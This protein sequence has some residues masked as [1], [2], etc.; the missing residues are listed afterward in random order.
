MREALG[1]PHLDSRRGGSLPLELHRALGDPRLQAQRQRPRVRP[2]RAGARPPTRS[3]T[4][5]SSTCA[6][7]RACAGT[8]STS[9]SRCRPRARSTRSAALSLR[10]G[11]GR[12]PAFAVALAAALREDAEEQE[13]DAAGRRSP[14]PSPRPCPSWPRCCA[15]RPRRGPSRRREV[16]IVF[17]ER[18]TVGPGRRRGRRG[19]AADRLAA[20]PR[21]DRPA[22]ACSRSLRS[23]TAAGCA[24][25]ACCRTRG[26]ASPSRRSAA[27]ATRRRSP[28]A[29]RRASSRRSICFSPTPC[30][31][32]PTP[33]CGAGRWPRASTVVAHASFLTE[34]IARARRR[35]LPGG[36]IRREGGHDR[37]PR[38]APAAAAPGDRPARETCAP[39]GG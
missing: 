34:A 8:S 5:R 25:P 28:K 26:P 37:A 4:R 13:L 36:G 17:G 39:D 32:C 11:P 6:C 3:T 9:P 31:T 35:R 1:S 14:A 29:S 2:R 21:R 24:R 19:A 12:G 30:S 38:R 20:R 15:A 27:G 10:F 22:P 7:A 23:P 18:L 16:V 33:S